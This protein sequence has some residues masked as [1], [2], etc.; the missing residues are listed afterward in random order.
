MQGDAG[1]QPPLG[2]QRLQNFTIIGHC[3]N[4][5]IA[6]S[7]VLVKDLQLRH[8]FVRLQGTS[9]FWLKILTTT[10]ESISIQIFVQSISLDFSIANMTACSSTMKAEAVSIGWIK[11]LNKP[12][13]WSL[14]TKAMAAEGGVPTVESSTLILIQEGEV[15]FWKTSKRLWS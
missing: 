9:R 12:P 4:N 2:G 14:Q 13:R 6:L 5:N 3:I 10:C 7:I 11:P 15:G 1:M 8:L